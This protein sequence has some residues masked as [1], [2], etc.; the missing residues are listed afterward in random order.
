VLVQ[1]ANNKIAELKRAE[2]MAK[3]KA[4]GMKEIDAAAQEFEAVFLSQMLEHMFAGV[5][6]NPMAGDGKSS[7]DDIYKSWLVDEYG[8]IIARSGG[9]GVADHVKREM[10]KM[11]EVN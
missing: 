10:L 7:Q 9:I 3:T 8:K 6:L 11:Q 1:H 4:A 5:N 2:R